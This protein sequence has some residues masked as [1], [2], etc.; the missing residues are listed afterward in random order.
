MANWMDSP[1]YQRVIQKLQAMPQWQ[2]AIFSSAGADRA[3][4]SDEMRSKID[5]INAATTKQGRAKSVSFGKER[6][7][8]ARDTFKASSELARDRFESSKGLADKRLRTDAKDR[9]LGE[10][11]GIGNLGMSGLM[12]YK[13]MELS[14]IQAEQEQAMR[15]KILGLTPGV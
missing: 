3:F 2:R 13:E 11:I 14:N 12:G 6:L 15:K 9:R 4:A 1:R 10:M 5:A 8:L 7:G